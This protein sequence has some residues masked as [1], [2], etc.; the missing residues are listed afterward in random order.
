MY[1]DVGFI[2]EV[3]DIGGLEYCCI[4]MV[5]EK[6]VQRGTKWYKV[7]SAA[8]YWPLGRSALHA[9]RFPRGRESV[10]VWANEHGVDNSLTSTPFIA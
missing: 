2:T 7:N 3:S 10:R 4:Q 5:K 8:R 9:L 1:L 6:W